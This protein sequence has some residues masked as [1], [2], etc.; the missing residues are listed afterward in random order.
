MMLWKVSAAKPYFSAPAILLPC[1][2]K[3]LASSMAIRPKQYAP[4]KSET[5]ISLLIT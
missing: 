4:L 3:T 5:S 2:S 1:F